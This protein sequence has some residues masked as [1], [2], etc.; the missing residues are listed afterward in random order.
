MHDPVNALRDWERLNQKIG[1]NLTVRFLGHDF[2]RLP[3]F[4]AVKRSI[5]SSQGSIPSCQKRLRRC[6]SLELHLAGPNEHVLKLTTVR[7]LG[8][9]YLLFL[10]RLYGG[11]I[12]CIRLA[13]LPTSALMPINRIVV[14]DYSAN[15]IKETTATRMIKRL[16]LSKCGVTRS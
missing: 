15:K 6:K 10:M 13:T 16:A 4:D 11:P 2:V 12:E 1:I 8:T 9:R 5:L 14:V 7:V 3:Q